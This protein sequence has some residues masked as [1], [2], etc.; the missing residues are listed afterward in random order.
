M[1]RS[2]FDY[3]F[4]EYAR[5]WAFK[6]PTPADF[7]RTMGDASGE[8]LD[9]FWRG[10]FYGT[11]PVDISLDTVKCSTLTLEGNIGSTGG[12]TKT[13][14]I[15]RPMLNTF[16][17][18]SKVRNREDNKIAFATDADTTLRDFYW[19]YDR[20]LAKVDTT[21]VET[22][23]P[24]SMADTFTNEQKTALA[25]SKYLYELTFS[26]RGGLVMPIIIEWTYKDSTKEVDR[27]PVQI[28]RKNENKV[29]KTFM[30][31]KEVASIKIDPM[32]E[33]ADINEKNNVWPV[34]DVPGKFQLFKSKTGANPRGGSNNSIN[35]MQKEI[36]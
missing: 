10:W 8:N 4:R 13:Q 28:W 19:R 14:N 3:A 35:P 24:V 26:N 27:I 36:K 16:D 1:G 15:S 5:R 25:G 29:T 17:D 6:H 18:I 12:N 33:T 21:P 32:R 2:L 23:I 34:I 11:D 20:G 30:K 22:M 9:W 31:N 7:F